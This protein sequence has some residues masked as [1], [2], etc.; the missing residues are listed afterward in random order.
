LFLVL[1]VFRPPASSCIKSEIL[2]SELFHYTVPDPETDIYQHQPGKLVGNDAAPE[3][4]AQVLPAGSAPASNSYQPN[5]ELNNQKMY[6]SASSTITGAT[7]GDVHT[8]LGHPGQGQT[9]NELRHADKKGGNGLAGLADNVGQGNVK[10][11]K[12][13]PTHAQQR[14]LGDVPTGQRGNTGGL[15]AQEREPETAEAVAADAT[16]QR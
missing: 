11:L 10:D 6:Q 9:S 4:T 1:R 5:P 14:N 13:D 15:P 12:D 8:G 7:S 3:F 2:R 16:K